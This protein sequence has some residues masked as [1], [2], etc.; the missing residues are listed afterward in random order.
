MNLPLLPPD[1]IN[2]QLNKTGIGYWEFIHGR[3]GSHSHVDNCSCSTHRSKKTE[4]NLKGPTK[5]AAFRPAWMQGGEVIARVTE[6]TEAFELVEY[7]KRAYKLRL[8]PNF[9]LIPGHKIYSMERL[10]ATETWVKAR[11]CA[12]TRVTGVRQLNKGGLK[13][14][15]NIFEIKA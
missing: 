15:C 7:W 14:P 9:L 13:G 12:A 5:P 2:I 4:Q 3:W 1:L 8:G 11:L 10:L 6:I